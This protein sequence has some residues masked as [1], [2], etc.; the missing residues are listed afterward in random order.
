MKL[1]PNP[2]PNLQ[3][4]VVMHQGIWC[5]IFY[6]YIWSNEIFYFLIWKRPFWFK[7]CKLLCMECRE[8]TDADKNDYIYSGFWPARATTSISYLFCEKLFAMWYHLRHKSPLNSEK[9]FISTIAEI[10]KESGR[11]NCLEF[12]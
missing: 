8:I 1:I 9:M 5:F 6:I 2:D 7:S 3:I 12:K 10:S 4:A 11:V